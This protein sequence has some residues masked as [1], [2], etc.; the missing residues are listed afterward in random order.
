MQHATYHWKV[1]NEGYNFALDL[2]AIKGLHK[3]LCTLKVVEVLVVAISGFPL[4]SLG[5]K[6]PFGC[7]PREEA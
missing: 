2:I 4:G 6:R 3:K 1:L 7:G 5:T